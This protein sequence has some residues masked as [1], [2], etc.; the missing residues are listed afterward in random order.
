MRYHF[1]VLGCFFILSIAGCSAK[2]SSPLNRQGQPIISDQFNPEEV[3]FPNGVP[4][5]LTL[6][7]LKNPAL[8]TTAHEQ[9]PGQFS[10]DVKAKDSLL[11]EQADFEAKLKEI[12]PQ[13]HVVYRY[14]MIL[15]ALAVEVP[16]D[17]ADKVNG[18]DIEFIEAD[19][20]FAM[21]KLMKAQ[22]KTSP[23]NKGGFAKTAMTFIGVDDLQGSLKAKNK[24]GEMVPVRGQGIK[25]GIIDTGADY[26]HSMLGG[27]GDPNDFKAIDPNKPS[28]FF[29][30]AKIVGGVDLAGA[31]FNTKLPSY[32]NKIPNPD[33]NPI[34]QSGHGTHVSG[35]VA[36]RG[37]GVRTYDG[38]APDAE[39]YALKVFGDME[40]GSTSDTTVIAALEYAADPN[41][42]MNP[43]DRLDV[44]NLSLGGNYGK[45]HSLYNVAI[46][47]LARGGT[48]VSVSAG[49]EGAISGVVGSPSTAEEALSV[50]AS[51]DGMEKNWRFSAVEF[52]SELHPQL[53]AQTVEGQITKPI[54]ITGNIKGEL[55]YLGTATVDLSS[56][57]LANLKG[58]VALIDRGEV[59]FVEK[60]Q[61]VSA[62]GVIGVVMV[63]NDDAEP[64]VM[65]GDIHFEFPGVMITKA[66][67]QVIKEDLVKGEVIVQFDS[68]SKVEKKQLIDTIAAFSSQGPRTIDALIKPEIT[69]PGYRIISAAMGSGNEGVEFSGTSMASPH[70]AGVT[71]LLRQYRSE[72]SVK[73]IKALLMNNSD[74]LSD[75]K[76]VRYP[77]SRQGAGLVNV[78]R[79]ARAEVVFSEPSLSLGEIQVAS[80]VS[81]TRSIT[82]E[83]ISGEPS[84][85]TLTTEQAPFLNI[86]LSQSMIS[87][88]PGQK[89]EIL[90]TIV[91]HTTNSDS[92]ELDGFVQIY[93]NGK[94]VGDIPILAVVNQMT[95]LGASVVTLGS[96]DLLLP[97]PTT[98]A[99]VMLTNAG[100]NAGSAYLFNLLGVDDRKPLIQDPSLNYTCD[101]ESVGYKIVDRSGESFLQIALK[102]Y[103][104]INSWRLCDVNIEFD[105]D[106]DQRSDK[107][108]IGTE[109]NGIP[110]FATQVAKGFRSVLFDSKILAELIAEY[111]KKIAAPSQTPPEL[112]FKPAVLSVE[113]MQTFDHSTLAIM[114]V[115]VK[116]L[117]VKDHQAVLTRVTVSYNGSEAVD[118]N[119]VLQTPNGEWNNVGLVSSA[120]GFRNVAESN[121]VAA[122]TTATV[123]IDRGGKIDEKLVVY[124]PRN[125]FSLGLLGQDQQSLVFAP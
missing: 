32:K 76:G 12:S 64:F 115:K 61:R 18:L 71:A 96:S 2:K 48:F 3:E 70:I 124:F 59:S 55:V 120:M 112:N 113:Q 106:G 45:P 39:L 26:T 78:Y 6:I 9:S 49:N 82:V 10:V 108:I 33:A 30:N 85:Y 28:S 44:V 19:E 68:D 69:A 117:N 93:Q 16:Q 17:V 77:V 101:L 36:G 56:E 109:L 99:Q 11:Q 50:A 52:N 105:T 79:A 62:S 90:V 86:E 15:N 107:E 4:M 100:N 104:P 65:G 25:V 121:I 37:D 67:G 57:Q 80:S 81:A 91:A 31:L 103:N 74:L 35:T 51:I 114:E 20:R 119:D 54:A 13:I 58:K 97:S 92:L 8:L 40:E 125:Q 94:R 102:I 116:D 22:Q 118:P 72:L 73:Q 7:Q 95:L 5:F 98:S 66:L 24:N 38:A 60:L 84:V 42:D 43:S 123:S 122:N 1:V 29:P 23:K 111:R 83:N 27:S 89:Q 110:G 88:A 87:L 75:E 14:R 34:D 46:N 53:L 63:N 47:T 41:Q 21:P